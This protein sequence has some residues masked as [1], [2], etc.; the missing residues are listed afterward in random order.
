LDAS[1][2]LLVWHEV[3]EDDNFLEVV[4]DGQLQPIAA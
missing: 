1:R 2:N 3:R 4:A